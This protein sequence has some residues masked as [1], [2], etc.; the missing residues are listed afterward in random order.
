MLNNT[1][2]CDICPDRAMRSLGAPEEY[3]HLPAVHACNA[4]AKYMA[5]WMRESIHE[6]YCDSLASW[7]D[8]H[9]RDE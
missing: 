4:H 3:G 1:K 8:D 9:Q 2:T 7:R 6:S 5:G